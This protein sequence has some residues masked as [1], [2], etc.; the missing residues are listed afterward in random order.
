MQS[1]YGSAIVPKKKEYFECL[2]LD[3]LP[4]EIKRQILKKLLLLYDCYIPTKNITLS[5]NSITF[6]F[7]K[8]QQICKPIKLLNHNISPQEFILLSPY[9]H[10]IIRRIN[11]PSV[12]DK[13][14]GC[15]DKLVSQNQYKDLKELPKSMRKKVNVKIIPAERIPMRLTAITTCGYG[16]CAI[17]LTQGIYNSGWGCGLGSGFICLFFGAGTCL[18][19]MANTFYP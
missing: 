11:N 5:Q 19:D 6:F 1:T 4:A 8:A 17:C 18:I 7:L 14:G 3:S 12:I 10:N 9:H 15:S 16:T 2:S 13:I